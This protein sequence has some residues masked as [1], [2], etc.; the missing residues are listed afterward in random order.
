MG[1]YE[2]YV[3]DC[4]T[5]TEKNVRGMLDQARVKGLYER[6]VCDFITD[7]LLDIEKET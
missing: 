2:I 6:Y 3:S 7:K 4:I 1:L 5:D